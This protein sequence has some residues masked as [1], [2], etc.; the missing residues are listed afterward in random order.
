MTGR[1]VP[2]VV[3]H[4]D[5]GTNSHMSDIL[6]QLPASANVSSNNSACNVL[7]SWS[8]RRVERSQSQS[9]TNSDPSE[10]LAVTVSRYIPQRE[11]FGSS[12]TSRTWFNW[13]HNEREKFCT[14]SAKRLVVLCSMNMENF[15]LPFIDLKLLRS[16]A[17]SILWKE[18]ARHK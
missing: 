16:K 6:L 5:D 2:T 9:D 12:W 11:S 4:D 3:R 15:F 18:M 17:L 10:S 14:I 13:L 7:T 1:V 8:R